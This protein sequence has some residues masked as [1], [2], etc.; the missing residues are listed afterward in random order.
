M[1][2]D[3][4]PVRAKVG[5]RHCRRFHNLDYAQNRMGLSHPAVEYAP[6]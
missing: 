4:G 2:L 5:Y 1:T 6:G 3:G